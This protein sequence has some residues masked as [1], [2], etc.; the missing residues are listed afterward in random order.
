MANSELVARNANIRA[1]EEELAQYAERFKAAREQ[2]QVL[3]KVN[4]VMNIIF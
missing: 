4:I 2:F 1:L 3:I